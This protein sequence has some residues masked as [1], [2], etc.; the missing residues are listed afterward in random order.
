MRE[1]GVVREVPAS[2]GVVGHS[3]GGPRDV[4][5]QGGVAVVPLVKGV[6]TEEV[7]T[8]GAGGRRTFSGPRQGRLVV[9]S[10]PNRVF[11]DGE[12]VGNNRFVGDGT[13]KFKI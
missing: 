13:S 5:V 3:I 6:E 1:E 8:S 10:E 9:P 2:A 4:V 7:G 12:M 11:S